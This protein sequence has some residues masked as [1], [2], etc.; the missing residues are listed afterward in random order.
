MNTILVIEDDPSLARGLEQSLTAEHFKV[1]LADT[2]LKGLACMKKEN[3][4]LLILD[5]MLPDTNGED[6]CR[7]LRKEGIPCRF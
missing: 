5:L 2:G 1:R 4:D 3:V 6:I 7:T